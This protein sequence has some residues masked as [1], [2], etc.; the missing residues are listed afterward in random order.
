LGLLNQ[1]T[2]S[3]VKFS[4]GKYRESGSLSPISASTTIPLNLYVAL[5]D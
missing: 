1:V 2:D 3:L 5:Y 4:E